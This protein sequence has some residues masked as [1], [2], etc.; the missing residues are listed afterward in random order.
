M[1]LQIF[2]ELSLENVNEMYEM[3]EKSTPLRGVLF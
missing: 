2:W 3:Y 1:P